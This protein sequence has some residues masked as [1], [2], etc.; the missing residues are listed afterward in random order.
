[1]RLYD[2][3]TYASK[4]IRVE[5]Y[6]RPKF[7]VSFKP[8]KKAYKIDDSVTVK[9]Q[10]KAFAGSVI[11]G[12]K[13]HYRVVRQ[14][15]FP[16]WSYRYGYNPYNQAAQEISNGDITTN[17]KGEYKITFKALADKNIP[18]DRKPIFTYTV[19]ADVTDITGETRSSQTAVRVGYIALDLSLDLLGTVDRD[20]TKDFGINTKNL[21]GQ[22][23]AAQGTITIEQLKHLK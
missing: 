2:T 21:N 14:A 22:F 15:R 17:E 13:V 9:G 5:E 20:Q 16:Y 1:M 4:Y 19:Y 12:A 8:I 3:K 7:E 18:K 6:K 11:D 10:A 23:E